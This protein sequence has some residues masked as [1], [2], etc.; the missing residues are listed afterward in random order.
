MF[1]YCRLFTTSDCSFPVLKDISPFCRI[2][3]V[4]CA[5]AIVVIVLRF[6]QLFKFI[7]M[8]KRQKVALTIHNAGHPNSRRAQKL[9]KNSAKQVTREKSKM[10]TAIKHNV[11]GEKILWFRDRIPPDVTVCS[12]TFV[13]ELL[14]QYLGRFDEEMEQIKIKHS[15]GHRGRQHASRE[16][17][18]RHTQQTERKEYNTCGLEIPN[19]L[20]EAQVKVLQEWTGELRFLQNFKLV[21]LGKKHLQESV[22]DSTM[23]TSESSNNTTTAIANEKTVQDDEKM[24]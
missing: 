6:V 13:D 17:M 3:P 22:P 18:I 7:T 14:Q 9:F 15:I 2:R 5:S 24:E 16:D 10:A 12:K 11:I 1:S 23:E 21:R 8:P 4:F 19:L 20:D